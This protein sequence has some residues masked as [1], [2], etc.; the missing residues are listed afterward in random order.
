MISANAV[1]AEW[2][3]FGAGMTVEIPEALMSIGAAV[4][5]IG[6]GASA[7]VALV[8]A[9][10]SLNPFADLVGFI[11]AVALLL[12]AF[13]VAI[14]LLRPLGHLLGALPFVGGAIESAVEGASNAIWNFV[15]SLV[16]NGLLAIWHVV[17]LIWAVTFGLPS[18][19]AHAIGAIVSVVVWL[20]ND[21]IPWV[22]S[23]AA[24]LAHNAEAAAD[25]FAI[26]EANAV[27]NYAHSLYNSAVSVADSLFRQAIATAVADVNAARAEAAHL[28]G[29]AESE[30]AQLVRSAEAAASAGIAAAV[31]TAGQLF[32]Q[33]ERDI[34]G[35]E[36]AAQRALEGAV[37]TLTGLFTGALT[38]TTATLTHTITT[39]A[40]RAAT[41]ERTI[42]TDFNDYMKRCGIPVCNG[43]GGMAK[44]MLGLLTLFGDAAVIELVVLILTNPQGAADVIREVIVQPAQ[45]VVQLV[46]QAA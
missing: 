5:A 34:A 20:R 29:E 19:V 6:G 42:A 15:T 32:G 45:D 13:A 16:H 3:T 44:E 24:S 46:R 26:A 43:L 41:A 9:A 27:S 7:G 30:A 11:V 39:E 40:E 4:E 35:A 1:A 12:I 33:A 38:A 22:R 31:A 21:M 2:G 28:F 23:E 25:H 8:A 17:K 10:V 37:G 18:T 36:A 14:L